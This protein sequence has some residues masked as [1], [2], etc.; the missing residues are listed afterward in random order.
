[1]SIYVISTGMSVNIELVDT[2]WLTGTHLIF[3]TCNDM[4]I[5]VFEIKGLPS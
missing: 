4:A 5:I 2:I 3:S 1:M